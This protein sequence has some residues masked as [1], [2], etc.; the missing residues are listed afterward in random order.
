MLIMTEQEKI[1]ADFKAKCEE[2]M[3]R[4]VTGENSNNSAGENINK[5]ISDEASEIIN[6]H[7]N[8][9]NIDA[10]ELQKDIDRI[11]KDYQDKLIS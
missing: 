9:P 7:S 10:E 1:T 4:Y 2:I 11:S 3:S 5:E 8:M 6:R